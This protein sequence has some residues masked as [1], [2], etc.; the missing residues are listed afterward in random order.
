MAEFMQGLVR[1]DYA[2]TFGLSDVGKVVT[3]M[4]WVQKRRNLGSLIFIDL[5][6]RT[7]IVQAVFDE[8]S[9]PE[10][11]KKAEAIRSEFVLAIKGM[12]RERE[13]K[14]DKIKTGAIEILASEL[15]I[16]AEAETTPFEILD[17]TDVN[18]NL[19]LKYRYLDLRRPS[20][21]NNL[22][23]RH[24]ITRTTR[25]YLDNIGFM[26]IETPM[27]G[28]S[29]P[30]GAREYLVPSRVH[31]AC[32]YALPQSPQLY[33][34][35]LMISGFDRYYQITKCFR[36]EDLR[37]NRQPEFTQIDLEM[38]FVE[39]ISDVIYPVEGLIKSVFKETLD[40]DF[41]E[42]HFR[43]M[44]YKEAMER[45]GSDKP[46]TRFGLELQDV[47]DIAKECDFKVFTDALAITGP[48]KGS[49]RAINAK[50]FASKLSRKDI[51]GLVEYVKTLGAKGLAWLSY[52]EGGEIKG[53]F[54]KFLSEDNIRKLTSK[55]NFE[56]GDVLFFAADKDYV[57]FNTLGGLR[58]HLAEKYSL[59]DKNT[60]DILWITEFPMFD[61]SEEEGR[62]V[63]VH[64]PFTAPMDEDL[65]LC[66]TDPLKARAKAYDIVI[67]GQEAGGGSIRIHR[68]DIQEK[69]FKI[70]GFTPEDIQNKFGFFVD[71]F[72]YGAPPHGGLALG[73][74]RLV[75]LITKN[76]SIK[77]VIAFPKVQ[78]A[79]CI[80]TGAPYLVDD[81][82]L[83]ELHIIPKDLQE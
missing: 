55:L 20:L 58:L 50:G 63:A 52:P 15:K 82:Q 23:T 72:R 31:K 77:D 62:L 34:Q 6:D 45:F 39:K 7:G 16:L 1:S 25:N 59:I 28:K 33:K 10:V 53:S 83:D 21:Q 27:L 71:A 32:F 68:R 5:R 69:M 40:I 46:D 12:V 30:E 41:G 81:K 14:T 4:G 51:D 9:T 37:A 67:N 70:L 44:P 60:Y 24:Q 61:Y 66:E 57:V 11:F 36:D 73:L 43:Q 75:M 56:E 54:L 17:D 38:S 42:E 3:V 79:S 26:E 13:N 65:D 2:G 49:V 74:D 8:A 80:M 22:I 18:E 78:T 47:S 35:L 29:S 64:H 48:V 19:R 76:D